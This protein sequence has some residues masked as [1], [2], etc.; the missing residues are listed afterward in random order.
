MAELKDGR[1]RERER[2]RE[3]ERLK[4]REE[5]GGLIFLLLL[6]LLLLLLLWLLFR[7][8]LFCCFTSSLFYLSFISLCRETLHL[9]VCYLLFSFNSLKFFLLFCRFSEVF[10]MNPKVKEAEQSSVY[11]QT[12]DEA[13]I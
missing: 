2:E 10:L 7:L 4:R 11:K 9:Q 1:D 8:H 3:R 5:G 12:A 6:F 13:V